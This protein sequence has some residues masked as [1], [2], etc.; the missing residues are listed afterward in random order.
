MERFLFAIILLIVLLIIVGVASGTGIFLKGWIREL[1][2]YV[3]KRVFIVLVLVIA[4][5]VWIVKDIEHADQRNMEYLQEQE[6]EEQQLENWNSWKAENADQIFD[7]HLENNCFTS[8]NFYF[9]LPEFILYDE[10]HTSLDDNRLQVKEICFSDSKVTLTLPMQV[11]DDLDH[12]K[13]TD[14]ITYQFEQYVN[15]Y[16]RGEFRLYQPQYQSSF[17]MILIDIK[18]LEQYLYEPNGVP[19]YYKRF[20]ITQWNDFS[21]TE[22]SDIVTVTPHAN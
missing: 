20:E 11:R 8:E 17:D 7:E 4:L 3:F 13:W 9:N 14:T 2:V 22:T 5:I 10:E 1:S 16:E 12:N 15:D 18:D 6:A 19:E 21:N